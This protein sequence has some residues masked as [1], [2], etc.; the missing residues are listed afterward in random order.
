RPDITVDSAGN[1]IVAWKD[2]TPGNTDI[3]LIRST[4]NGS[5]WSAAVNLSNNSGISQ[6]PDITVDS[7]GNIIVAWVNTA[8]GSLD[9]FFIRSTD[10]G[11]SWS[12]AANLSNNLGHSFTPDITVDSAGNI[13]V[14]WQDYTPGNA[15]IF[16]I[17]STDNGSS[18]STAVN[19]SNDSLNSFDPAITVD[20]LGNINVVWSGYPSGSAEILFRR[21]TDNGSSWS[22]AANL[23]NTSANSYCPA[24]IVDSA[25][26]INVVWQDYTTGNN[27]IFFIRSTD[28]GSSWSAAANI[29]KNPANSY[30]P[31]MTIDSTGNINIVW[32][33]YDNIPGNADIFFSGSTR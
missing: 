19:I 27:D 22:A 13:I 10:N 28:N 14:A 15:D 2:N 1:I 32:Y 25:G 26:N 12:A 24:I 16:F 11:S 17:R 33:D 5:S 20:S 21:S 3:L 8:P 9:I 31:A 30:G 29:S 6:S 18:W 7:A 4:D 23:S